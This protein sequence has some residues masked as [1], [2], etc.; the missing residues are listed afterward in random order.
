MWCCITRYD[1]STK[2]TIEKHTIIS[3]IALEV[4]QNLHVNPVQQSRGISNIGDSVI[5]FTRP[6]C[7]VVRWIFA[8]DEARFVFDDQS[9]VIVTETRESGSDVLVCVV[10]VS[11][12]DL[13]RQFDDRK[14][15]VVLDI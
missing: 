4:I 7:I 11:F 12:G 6:Y 15:W 2:L 13:P 10:L 3:K 8:D 9:D 14:V 1:G 5:I